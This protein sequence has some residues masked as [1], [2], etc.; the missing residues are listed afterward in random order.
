VAR[1]ADGADRACG[2]RAAGRAAQR[3]GRGWAGVREAAGRARAGGGGA[4]R[5]A[6]GQRE[7]ARA[8]QGGLRGTGCWP[9]G[10]QEGVLL[11]RVRDWG[12]GRTLGGLM[13]RDGLRWPSGP[14]R[15]RGERGGP[16]PI[17]ISSL[18]FI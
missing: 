2:G 6:L 11:G 3:L 7:G 10:L 12:K 8:G 9:S 17:S 5:C 15:G 14:G 16:F 4:P 13:L 18:F 1:L